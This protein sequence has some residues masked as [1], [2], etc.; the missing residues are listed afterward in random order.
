[1][2]LAGPEHNLT[3]SLINTNFVSRESC[4]RICLKSPD[5]SLF[6]FFHVLNYAAH[7]HLLLS[8]P[9]SRVSTGLSATKADFPLGFSPDLWV[10]LFFVFKQKNDRG[11]GPGD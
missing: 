11:L 4:F 6:W 7:E 1:M 9:S 2:A 10:F 3:N 5:S 8:K